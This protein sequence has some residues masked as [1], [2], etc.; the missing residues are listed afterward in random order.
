MPTPA[1]ADVREIVTVQLSPEQR[2]N[3]EAATGV[4]LNELSFFKLSGSAARQLNPA[5]LE[6]HAV[7]A[8]W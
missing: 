2:S 6:G 7:V 3:I 4:K 1:E 5:L 8:C